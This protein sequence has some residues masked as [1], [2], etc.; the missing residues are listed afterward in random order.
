MLLHS[1]GDTLR[2]WPGPLPSILGG[3]L[4]FE[5]VSLLCGDAHLQGQLLVQDMRTLEATLHPVLP[6]PWCEVCGGARSLEIE[7]APHRGIAGINSSE[8][9]CRALP[10]WIDRRTG[11]IRHVMTNSCFDPDFR[12][13]VCAVATLAAYTDGTAPPVQPGHGY[14]KGLCIG[15]AL[16]SAVGEALEHYSAGRV[17]VETLRSARLCDLSGE[18]LNPHQLCLYTEDQ[19]G[20]P[21]FPFVS[22]D[23]TTPLLWTQGYWLDSG[24]PVWI[25]AAAVYLS[26]SIAKDV[27]I[28]QATSNG[29]ATGANAEDAALRAVLELVERDAFLISWLA[30]R[31]GRRLLLDR[32]MDP[33][34][35]EVLGA[36]RDCGAQIE[37]YLV[38]VGFSIPTA[39]CLAL[40]CGKRWPG[41]T[42]GLGTD[43][44]PGRAV[45]KAI[46]ELGQ[47][48]PYLRRLMLESEE[49]IPQAPEQV[50]SFRDHALY[51]LP[52]ERVAAFDFFRSSGEEPCRLGSLPE[53]SDRSLTM[54]IAHVAAAGVRMALVDVTAPDVALSPFRVVRAVGTNLQQVSYGWGLEHLGN[55][56][57]RTLLTGPTNPHPHP[58]C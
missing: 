11:V 22:Y 16:I 50:K 12:V 19:Y 7:N 25:P 15:E 40:G 33:G 42:L 46:L 47:T 27:P 53:P 48:G 17:R 37:F 52:P 51:Y 8:D 28:C 20:R 13:P 58:L 34:I 1:Q 6:L 31:P 30:R 18:V 39:V 26:P 45:R 38:D 10:G 49:R 41:V 4:A 24:E 35:D 3:L 14:G 29:L 36:L 54:C 44:S 32:A 43:L 9:L 55:P 23:A 5:A 56:R 2:S 21:D 57:L